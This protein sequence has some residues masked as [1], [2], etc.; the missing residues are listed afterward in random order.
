[1]YNL[2]IYLDLKIKNINYKVYN[3]YNIRKFK[4]S[5]LQFI[6]IHNIHSNGHVNRQSTGVPFNIIVF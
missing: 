2:Y 6:N 4:R 1:M 5:L 3:N